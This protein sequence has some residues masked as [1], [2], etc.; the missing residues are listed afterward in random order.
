VFFFLF[1]SSDRIFMIFSKKLQFSKYFRIFFSEKGA[2]YTHFYTE[3]LRAKSIWG[4]FFVTKRCQLHIS[5]VFA[6][7]E[8]KLGVFVCQKGAHY[9]HFYSARRRRKKHLEFLCEK[10]ASYTHFYSGRRRRKKNLE[11]FCVKKVPVIHIS[12]I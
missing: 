8:K 6:A 3:R 10:G 7:G 5:T 1:F 9:T 4:V 11:F 12:G 2:S